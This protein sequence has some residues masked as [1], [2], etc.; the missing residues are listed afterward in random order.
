M[1]PGGTARPLARLRRLGFWLLAS[2]FW[3]LSSGLHPSLARAGVPELARRGNGLYARGRYEEALVMYRQAGVIE[4]DAT[5]LRYNTG[6]TLHRL[7]RYDEALPE[8]ELAL[9][10][11]NP[12]RRADAMYNIGNTHFRADRL[13]AA[14]ASYV[15]TL[16]LNPQDR[17]A[18]EN[19]EFA[20]KK[21]E[22]M[23][24]QQQQQDQSQSDDEQQQEQQQQ[25]QPQ[26][27]PEMGRDEA[28]R[29]IQAVE[30]KEKEEQQRQQAP[31]QKRQV[32]RDW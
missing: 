18:K 10:D 8:L 13:D 29:M 4:P 23:E 11:R 5:T 14:I 6:N 21:K 28:E 20:L 24:K 31:R 32:E 3:L 27:K 15:S 17:A 2:G 16:V 30:N 1:L 7:G 26:P 25:Q 9:T 22:E 19:L 12:R